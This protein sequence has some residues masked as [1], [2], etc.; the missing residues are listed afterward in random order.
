MKIMRRKLSLLI[1]LALCIPMFGATPSSRETW[2]GFR[3]SG[4]SHTAAIR[5]PL[6]WGD[7][8]NVAWR[9]DLPG[10]GQSSPVVWKNQV[11]LTSVEGTSKEKLLVSA[12]DLKRGG[13]L[14]LNQ[15]DSS[16]PMK[17]ANTVS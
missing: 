5:L 13:R 10:Y 2:P 12:Y 4:D 15:Y 17:D 16:M 6:E 11:F 9:A 3:G 8:R 7:Q 14:W 1:V